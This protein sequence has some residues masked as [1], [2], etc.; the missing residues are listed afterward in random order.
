MFRINFALLFVTIIIT[1]SSLAAEDYA[2]VFAFKC[3]DKILENEAGQTNEKFTQFCIKIGT[4]KE[5]ILKFNVQDA[6]GETLEATPNAILSAC[7]ELAAQLKEN[8]TL[9]IIFTGYVSKKLLISA[10]NG[11]LEADKLAASL[12]KI[13]AKRE[14]YIFTSNSKALAD[15][16]HESEILTVSGADSKYQAQTPRI[17]PFVMD[18]LLKNHALITDG[19][20]TLSEKY[21]TILAKAASELNDTISQT[22]IALS[23]NPFFYADGQSSFY[24]FKENKSIRATSD[25]TGNTQMQMRNKT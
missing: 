20:K 7:D 19:T 9:R 16:L 6:S 22:G 24:P 12:N 10:S 21:K 13:K 15:A 14:Y 3:G 2:L 11:R 1:S 23:E 5:N 8:D 17:A 4:A 18:A 25:V